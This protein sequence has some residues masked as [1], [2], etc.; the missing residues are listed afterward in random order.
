MHDQI[1]EELGCA[2]KD[3]RAVLS[4]WSRTPAYQKA[5]IVEGARRRNLDGSE[6]GEVTPEQRGFALEKLAQA[7][8][9]K[10]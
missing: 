7:K 2:E 5:L 9:A 3:L 8:A 1:L 4:L 10:V 6:A